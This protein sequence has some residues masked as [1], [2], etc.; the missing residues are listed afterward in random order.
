VKDIVTIAGITVPDQIFGL[1]YR[2]EGYAFMN[3]PF[4]GIVGLSFPT[5]AKANSVPFFD[6]VMA[7]KLL[8]NNIF[9]IYLSEKD[10]KPNIL[11]GEIDKNVMASNFT[12]VD[13]V[14]KGYWEINIQDIYIG[15][16]KTNYCDKIRSK[17][18]KCGVALDSGTSLY[19]GPS[20]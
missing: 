1:T 15:E 8:Q 3:V 2:E 10:G 6:S 4:E 12:F 13:V 16:K 17:T 5:T 11:F 7:H 14:S 9:S 19:A 20:E 18:G